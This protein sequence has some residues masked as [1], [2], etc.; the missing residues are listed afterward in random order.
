MYFVDKSVVVYIVYS[1]YIHIAYKQEICQ[2]SDS[3]NRPTC[4]YI[5]T[6][7]SKKYI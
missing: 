3:T 2:T 4:V 1:H 7:L 6:Y 5:T